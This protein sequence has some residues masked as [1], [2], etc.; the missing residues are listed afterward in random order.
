MVQ[1]HGLRKLEQAKAKAVLHLAQGRVTRIAKLTQHSKALL[2]KLKATGNS[3]LLLDALN[4]LLAD[5]N[6]MSANVDL[7]KAQQQKKN[8][9]SS[10]RENTEAV[11]NSNR[12]VIRRRGEFLLLLEDFPQWKQPLE[13]ITTAISP[14][15]RIS[16]RLAA[17]DDPDSNVGDFDHIRKS[18]AEILSFREGTQKLVHEILLHKETIDKTLAGIIENYAPA[19]VTPVDRAILRLATYEITQCEDIPKAVSINEAVEIAKRFSTTESSR[20]I[21]G[22]LDAI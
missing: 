10:P 12:S 4:Q 14:L 18:A 13:P 17:I 7:L 16:E 21:N 3:D 15:E 22:V 8:S 9:E 11:L 1:E 6:G 2:R 20:F 19:R 5:E